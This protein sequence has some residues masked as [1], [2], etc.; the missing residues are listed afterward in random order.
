MYTSV[1]IPRE[2]YMNSKIISYLQKTILSIASISLLTACSS[3]EQVNPNPIDIKQDSIKE[4]V[5][6]EQHEAIGYNQGKIDGFAEGVKW[7]KQT[8]DKTIKYI[9]AV[10]FTSYLVKDNYIQPGPVYMDENGKI[11]LSKMEIVPPYTKA[12]IFTK[13]GA[14][15][16]RFIEENNNKLSSLY[17]VNKKSTQK[18]APSP[19]ATNRPQVKYPETSFTPEIYRKNSQTKIVNTEAIKQTYVYIH[20]TKSNRQTLERFGYK[21]GTIENQ[22]NQLVVKFNTKNEAYQFC[23][24]F[25]ICMD[26]VTK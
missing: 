16:P 13:F 5:Q 7:S 10:Q 4:K 21:V 15:L 3:K 11:H 26:V 18:V 2:E 23:T 25:D 12:D 8:M 1:C 22:D 6:K 24:N 20:G 14:E 19:V 9:N 17:P